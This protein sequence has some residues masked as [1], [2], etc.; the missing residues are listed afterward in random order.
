MGMNATYNLKQRLLAGEKVFGQLIGPGNDPE[1]TVKALKEMGD[2][3]LMM[4]TEHSLVHKETV[5]AFIRAAKQMD[6][7][8]MMRT[9]DKA[10]YFRCFLDAGVN[11]LMLPLVDTVEEAVRAVNKAYFPP[12]GH[13]GCAISMNP[14]LVDSQDL[15]K[16]PYL[17]L[18]EYINNNVVVFPQTESL[19]N[20]NNLSRI[21][22]IEGVTGTI[23]GPFDLALDIGGIDPKALLS[24]V[25]DTPAVN[26]RLQ[27][28]VDICRES[29]KV[30]GIGGCTPKRLAYWAKQG[31]QL[32]L[33]GYV[34][35]GN[36]EKL[37]P[38]IKESRA[39]I[40]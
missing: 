25:V 5:Y 15:S 36:V 37:R 7:P 35:D 34:L 17:S 24:E 32:L 19:E 16:V 38:A 26:A 21:L 6:M 13:R 28:I 30:A 33:V 11:G 22:K 9:E 3:F 40:G 2:D 27:Q 12:I 29:G 23:V 14:F 18:T 10:A 1:K 39:L 8:I 20:I 31:Y 4:E